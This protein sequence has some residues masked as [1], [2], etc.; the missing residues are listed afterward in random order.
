MT[1]MPTVRAS[2]ALAAGGALVA[3]L[4]LSGCGTARPGAA[5]VVGDQRISTTSLQG[6]VQAVQDAQAEG[7]GGQAPD[8]AKVQRDA[9][10][11]RIVGLIVDE[12][13]GREGV[14]V[15]RGEVDA[16]LT[17]VEE[18]VGGR[19]QLEAALLQDGVSTTELPALLRQTV[20]VEKIG[21]DLVPGSGQ[22]VQLQRQQRIGTMLSRV[23]KD[24]GVTVNPRYGR[25]DAKRA[26][27]VP[28]VNDLSRPAAG[29]PQGAAVGGG[30]QGG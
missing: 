5:A 30:P 21:E 12:A 26:T 23:S 24:I 1:R 4:A 25:W 13:A 29:S 22:Q 11:R 19:K 18:G 8:P 28:D 14:T 17:Q 27:L 2:A 20:Q 15:D 16:R 7:G 9:L 10:S 3:L 6:T